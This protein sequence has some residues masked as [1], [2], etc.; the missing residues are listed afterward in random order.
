MLA[1]AEAVTAKRKFLFKVLQFLNCSTKCKKQKWP[2]KAKERFEIC[3][4]SYACKL[5]EMK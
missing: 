2:T 3:K 4:K 1:A 5:L